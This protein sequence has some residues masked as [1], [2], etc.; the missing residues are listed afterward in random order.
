MHA[1]AKPLQTSYKVDQLVQECQEKCTK[2]KAMQSIT[3][4]LIEATD[5]TQDIQEKKST[6]KR[7]HSPS[8]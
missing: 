4:R 6:R 2:Q 1:V 7:L 8:P 3:D 5:F